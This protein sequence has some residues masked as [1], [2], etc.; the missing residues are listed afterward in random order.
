MWKRLLVPKPSVV[1]PRARKHRSR[2]WLRSKSPA[3]ATKRSRPS[4]TSA[5]FR[6][7]EGAVLELDSTAF[8]EAL[9]V[10]TDHARQARL[11]RNTALA[12]LE[13]VRLTSEV[14]AIA[15]ELA[16][17]RRA[18]DARGHSGLQQT[19]QPRSGR[20]PDALEKDVAALQQSLTRKHEEV[21][22]KHLQLE[23]LEHDA[24]EFPLLG[25]NTIVYRMHS[26]DH[27]VNCSGG[28]YE[29]LSVVQRTLP[30]W[31]AT[32]SR[33]RWWWYRDRFWWVDSRL[34]SREVESAILDLDLASE[35]QRELVEHARADLAGRSDMW[36]RSDAADNVRREVWFRDKG[37][38][39]DCGV[40]TGLAYD[41]VLALAVGGSTEAPNLELRCRQCQ[42]RRRANEAKAAVG[43]ARIGA[44]AA[45]EW[46]V[47]L[48]DVGWPGGRTALG[49][50]DAHA[51]E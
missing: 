41:H 6:L 9:E 39:V 46:G 5:E 15:D 48:K 17:A 31:L 22:A 2:L 11:K 24:Q 10:P 51:A 43:K 28:Q 49:D 18:L 7:P 40:A 44:Q 33:L 8:V 50:A 45:K 47:E 23:G 42:M 30:V 4:A 16:A 27:F 29:H 19:G 25:H 34:G 3:H 13:L 14:D 35:R 21:H 37:R 32:R 36:E 12:R 38:C 26:A 1:E 20:R